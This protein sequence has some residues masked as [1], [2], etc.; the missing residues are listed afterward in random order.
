MI[1]RLDGM[2]ERVD[3]SSL[4][5][6]IFRRQ[7]R[8]AG[9]PIV[10]TGLLHGQ[11][12]WDL[13]FLRMQLQNEEISVRIYGSE[14]FTLP[15][16]EWKNY[17]E[18]QN[19]L[20][21]SYAEMLLSGT[22]GKKR[23]YLAQYNVRPTRLWSPVREYF[24]N[25]AEKTGLTPHGNV[26]LW[27]GPG[28]HTEPLHFDG[29]DGTLMQIYGSKEV[30]LFPPRESTN[31]YPFPIFGGRLPPWF[32]KVYINAPDL[33]EFPRLS[34]ALESKVLVTLE[35][36]EV[37]FIPAF[38]WHEVTA[39]GSGSVCSLNRFWDVRPLRRNLV[40]TRSII[41]YLVR[42]PLGQ[43]LFR[44]TAKCREHLLGMRKGSS[45]T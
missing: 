13:Q 8:A 19:M 6:E 27:L 26:N 16:V 40:T 37:L 21:D 23:A 7:Y 33:I 4:N 41:S 44:L 10:I 38:W 20:F 22:A 35:P 12:H 1:G 24:D 30:A 42:F 9:I 45:S 32:S 39:S 29:Y 5:P 25:L 28:G 3:V 43:S 18:Q 11:P 2:V 34:R 31:L 17:C 15:K 36:G 14:R